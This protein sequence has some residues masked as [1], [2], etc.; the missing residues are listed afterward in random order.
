M[1][2]NPN[3]L[4]PRTMRDSTF[5]DWADPIERPIEKQNGIVL[6]YVALLVVAAVV[7]FIWKAL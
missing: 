1:N 6:A 3:N 2:R 5:Q 7:V 4:S